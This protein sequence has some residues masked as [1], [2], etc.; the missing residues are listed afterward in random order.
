MPDD[1]GAAQ[2]VDQVL[3]VGVQQQPIVHVA[4]LG[5]AVPEKPTTALI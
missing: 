3:V 1:H 4:Y 5:Y 2:R